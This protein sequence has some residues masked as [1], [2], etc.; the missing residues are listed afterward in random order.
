M[1]P[2]RFKERLVAIRDEHIPPPGEGATAER[3]RRLMAVG[4]EDL[5]VARL[6]EAHWDAVAIL[7]E[8]GN[9]PAPDSL[10]GVW[11]SEIPG[12]ALSIKPCDG[13]YRIDGTKMFCSGAGLVD[14]AL[15]T[16]GLP[17]QR[18]VEVDLRKNT[19]HIIIDG[20]A[21]KTAAFHLTQTSTVTFNAVVVKPDAFVGDAGWYL[22][23]AGFWHGACGPAACWAGG[24]AGLL[25]YA[26]LNKR[27]DVHTLAHLAAMHAN[28]WALESYLD[29]AGKE[30]DSDPADRRA[31]QI[32]A[33]QVR[34]LVEQSCT[35]TIRRFARA[36]GPAPLSMD[37]EISL[38][39]QEVDLYVRQSHA[40]RDLE[41]LA[42]TLK[43]T[44]P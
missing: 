2:D 40:E 33:L 16:I 12:K 10:Y 29:V 9:S 44:E 26:M 6:A 18:L 30:I 4:R 24:A 34:H 39:Y 41:S 11:A 21:W 25:D 19:A 42:Q 36:Y 22:D 17:E 38:R 43:A 13:G 23:R 14:R 7:A 5:S 20:T 3:L 28:V 1:T 32:R 8:A 15:I 37:A 27:E 35:D 31:A